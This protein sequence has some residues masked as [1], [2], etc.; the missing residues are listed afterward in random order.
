MTCDYNLRLYQNESIAE[1][2]KNMKLGI[3]QMILCAPTGAGK[4][5][6]FSYMVSKAVS[7]GKRCLIITDRIELISQAGGTLSNFGLQPVEIKAGKKL[8]STNAMLYTAMAQTLSRRMDQQEY[9]D[10]FEKLDLIIIDEGHKQSFNS[11]IAKIPEKCF[12]IAATATPFRD[13]NQVSLHEFYKAIV[14]VVKISKLVD[15]GFLAIP[16]TFGVKVDLSGIRISKGDYDEAQVAARYSET[17]LFHGVYENYQRI[18]SGKKALIFASNVS[19]SKELV[20]DFKEKGLPIEHLDANTPTAERK[21]ILKWFKET[22][23]AMLSNVGILNAG[24]DEPTIEVV[25][26]Y[27][28]TKSLPLFLQMC[29]RGSRTIPGIKDKFIIMDFGNNVREHGFWEQD[30]VWSLI[31]KKKRDGIPPVKDCPSCFAMLPASV[32]EC[33]YCGHIFEKT[34]KEKQEDVIAELQQLSYKQIQDQIKTADFSKLEQIALAK[35]YKKTW[36]F[37]HLKT[38]EDLRAYAKF[39]NYHPKWVEHQISKREEENA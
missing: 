36:I 10:L 20:E 15:D 25:I 18:A 39:K 13:K 35:G 33:K 1:L 23:G 2:R 17:K 21:R 37:Y 8:K 26:L 14:E 28:A 32:P 19:S 27:R 5:V 12:V 30:R 11:I 6:M 9:L 7:N 24:F 3:N 38:E 4:T 22:Q 31:K 29:G 34:E 16:E